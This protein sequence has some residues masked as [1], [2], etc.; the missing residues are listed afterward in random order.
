VFRKIITFPP[1]VA[2]LAALLLR[3]IVPPD[4]LQDLLAMTAKS[5]TPVVMVAIGVQMRLLLPWDELS[6]LA[7]GLFL[8]L[9]VTP[10]VFVGACRLLDLSGPAV[11]VSL[12]ET[13]MPPMVMASV[14]ASVAGLKLQLSSAMAA[15]GILVAFFT[16]PVIFKLM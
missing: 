6:P 16:L 1:F 14:L 10:L 3:G 7:L 2:L 9:L 5:M 8:R 13:A 12:L 4:W 15:Y 11:Q